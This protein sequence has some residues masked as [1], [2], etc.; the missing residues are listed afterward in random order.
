MPTA[1]PWT[2]AAGAAGYPVDD[3][4]AWV[5]DAGNRPP[6]GLLVDLA[7]RWPIALGERAWLSGLTLSATHVAATF[8][9][10]GGAIA[11]VRVARAAVAAPARVIAL[12]DGVA[13]WALFARPATDGGVA[14]ALSTEAQGRLA[15]RAARPYR[16][17]AVRSIR[18]A[19]A[20]TKLTGVVDLVGD[21]P[22]AVGYGQRWI[23]DRLRDVVVLYMSNAGADPFAAPDQPAADNVFRQFAGPCGGRPESRTCGDPQPVEFVAGVGPDCDGVLTLRFEGCARVAPLAGR[24]GVRVDCGLSLD[25]ACPAP[26]LPAADGTLPSEGPPP[27][28]IPAV[29][30]APVAGDSAS[31]SAGAG[32]SLPYSTCFEAGLDELAPVAGA[33][34]VGGLDDPWAVCGVPAGD[35]ASGPTEG[36]AAVAQSAATRNVLVW[37]NSPGNGLGCQVTTR[38]AI[39]PG[40]RENA[41]VVANWRPSPSV[42]T[43]GTYTLAGID[44][45]TQT[46]F[47]SRFNGYAALPIAGVVVPGLATE[48]VYELVVTVRPGRVGEASVE[49]ALAAG[50]GTALATLGPVTD[51]DYGDPDGLFGLATDRAGA[52]FGLFEVVAAP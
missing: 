15:L 31:E 32:E 19:H 37:G 3:G 44:L 13:G 42:P 5:D 47:V 4:A 7:L 29:D 26:Y 21:G 36:R 28:E 50:D 9:T 51:T 49:V 2:S 16:P 1:L 40:V 43:A 41:A 24:P 30:P 22:L 10:A 39:T 20:A 33:W 23:A 14:H 18:A 12:A 48:A 52:R 6:A 11:A 34:A 46:L 25:A 38:L 35:S 27:A 17:A 45:A 8:A